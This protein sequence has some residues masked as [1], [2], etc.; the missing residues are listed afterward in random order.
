MMFM[1]AGLII[2]DL[3][4]LLATWQAQLRLILPTSMLPLIFFN[5]VMLSFPFFCSNHSILASVK[6]PQAFCS[7]PCKLNPGLSF[8]FFFCNV[9][10]L[11]SFP[12]HVELFIGS[13]SPGSH[14]N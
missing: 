8:F 11:K 4:R 7:P 14:V 3:S 13:D 2:D 10:R 9:G 12:K 1:K 5:R 6:R